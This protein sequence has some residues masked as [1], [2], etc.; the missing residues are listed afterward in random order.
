MAHVS[1]LWGTT[2]PR[3]GGGGSSVTPTEAIIVNADCLI[4]DD[5]RKCVYVTSDMVGSNLQVAT[6]DTSDPA[7]MPVCGIILSK[8][9][10]TV[11]QVLLMGKS[12]LF[13][14][15]TAGKQY[16]CGS[17]SDL[18]LHPTGLVYAQSLG[19]ALSSDTFW[20]NAGIV[21]TL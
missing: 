20:F 13:S 7:K 19:V 18:V 8:S 10:D 16:W 6:A 17:S 14:G 3:G 15:L 9:S 5:V 2:L 1:T 12:S 21:H 11:C 4:T